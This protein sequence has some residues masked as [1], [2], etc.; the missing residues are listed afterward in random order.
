ME[1]LR[2]ENLRLK[3]LL[4][5]SNLE[6]VPNIEPALPE[7]QQ[8]NVNENGKSDETKG[9]A[10]SS[11]GISHSLNEH[12]LQVQAASDL[13]GYAPANS[14]NEPTSPHSEEGAGL[15]SSLTAA[16]AHIGKKVVEAGKKLVDPPV[17]P[18]LANISQIDPHLPMEPSSAQSSQQMPSTDD[19]A[20]EAQDSNEAEQPFK[21]PMHFTE[22]EEQASEPEPPGDLGPQP[23]LE[24]PVA[25]E[26]PLKVDTDFV[27]NGVEDIPQEGSVGHHSPP[28]DVDEA[29][30]F[31]AK[32]NAARREGVQNVCPD[33]I[34]G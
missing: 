30:I 5:R 19:L 24:E 12:A 7:P 13:Y 8:A 25:A 14:W 32:E 18:L 31:R 2:E 27:A 16:V 3:E 26:L 11:N 29:L 4:K 21:S 1:L 6:V 20:A 22:A 17:P 34:H 9:T 23:A 15:A 10:Y 33:F 28:F